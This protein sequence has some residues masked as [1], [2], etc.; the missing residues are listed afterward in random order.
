MRHPVMGVDSV[1]QRWNKPL[2]GRRNTGEQYCSV[3][4]T[5][6]LLRT[7]ELIRRLPLQP[8]FWVGMAQ[9]LLFQRLI[10]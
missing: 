3:L 10:V 6:A 9:A 5:L 1:A 8:L 2:L 7:A 4:M